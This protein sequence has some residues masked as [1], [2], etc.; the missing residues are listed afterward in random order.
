ML[1]VLA[2]KAEAS[3]QLLPSQR[4]E[5]LAHLSLFLKAAARRLAARLASP[6]DEVA[7]LDAKRAE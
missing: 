7:H 3:G 5:F 1:R 4:E 6:L 2:D